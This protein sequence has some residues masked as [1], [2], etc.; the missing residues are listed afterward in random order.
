MTGYRSAHAA[1]AQGA[2]RMT[3]DTLAAME[4]AKGTDA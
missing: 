1:S 2:D 4:S 3:T